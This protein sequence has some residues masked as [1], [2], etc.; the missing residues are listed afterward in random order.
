MDPSHSPRLDYGPVSPYAKDK[1]WGIV[2]VALS[3][4]GI[5]CGLGIAG[6]GSLFGAFGASTVAGDAVRNG[7]DAGAQMAFLGFGG[8][9]AILGLGLVVCS[10]LQVAGGFGIM[11]SRRW[12]FNLTLAFSA[13]S[14]LFHLPGVLHGTGIVGVAVNGVIAWYCWS[15]LSGKDGPPP[16]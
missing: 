5:C 14:I 13:I 10:G 8:L 2:V 3:V 6:A 11:A 9:L 12:G 7:A 1:T 4:L 15:R 16:V